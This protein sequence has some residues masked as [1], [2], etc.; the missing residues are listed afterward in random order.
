MNTFTRDGCFFVLLLRKNA[1]SR[2]IE[3]FSV[4]SVSNI[5][6]DEVIVLGITQN[7]LE[8]IFHRIKIFDTIGNKRTLITN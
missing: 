1:V 8:N 2:V 6:V 5:L 7:R 4:P 3:T